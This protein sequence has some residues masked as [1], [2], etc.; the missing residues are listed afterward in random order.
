[1]D[2]ADAQSAYLFF[3][4]RPQAV[5]LIEPDNRRRRIQVANFR[6]DQIDDRHD[7]AVR[8]LMRAEKKECSPFLLRI[9]GEDE[10]LQALPNSAGDPHNCRLRY[11]LTDSHD[12]SSS[13]Y[14]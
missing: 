4:C 1:M 11:L 13:R 6:L 10:G 3:Q 9:A 8:R 12:T 5:G 7:D 2:N 14:V